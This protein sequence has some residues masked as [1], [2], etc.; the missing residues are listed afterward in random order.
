MSRFQ[1]MPMCLSERYQTNSVASYTAHITFR[2]FCDYSLHS[3]ELKS[4]TERFREQTDRTFELL[5]CFDQIIFE[6]SWDSSFDG[7]TRLVSSP[8]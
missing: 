6:R 1:A 3:G 2:C 7:T 4:Q 8:N 5:Q